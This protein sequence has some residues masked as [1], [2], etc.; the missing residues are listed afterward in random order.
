M[1]YSKKFVLVAIVAIISG[2]LFYAVNSQQL[3]EFSK[4]LLSP[5]ERLN[6]QEEKLK[7]Q[8]KRLN[9]QGLLIQVL[10]EKIESLSSLDRLV[11][12]HEQRLLNAE[13]T[14]SILEN[15]SDIRSGREL[16]ELS[17]I[18]TIEEFHRVRKE[19]K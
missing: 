2:A 14:I 19:M 11:N 18:K 6:D 9:D 15:S 10:N 16:S 12:E 3:P 8:E 5:D 17:E 7:D 1:K 4:Q 13:S